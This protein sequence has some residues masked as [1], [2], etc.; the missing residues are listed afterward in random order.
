MYNKG[1]KKERHDQRSFLEENKH[2]GLC[3]EDK[4][5]GARLCLDRA[6]PTL[7]ASKETPHIGHVAMITHVCEECPD[8]V[9]VKLCL[10]NRESG[11]SV[12]LNHHL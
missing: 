3:V 10:G 8:P 2:L 9:R 4:L 1:L 6:G 12:H 11:R 7:G 5:A